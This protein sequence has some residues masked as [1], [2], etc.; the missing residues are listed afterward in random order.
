LAETEA[1]SVDWRESFL[2]T[3]LERD[4]AQLG[5]T[6]PAPTLRRFWTMVA[7]YHGQVWNATEFAR[8]LGSSEGTARRYL[9]ILT[10]AAMVRQL[11]GWRENI[12]KRQLKAPK[13]YVRDTGLLHT[14][15]TLETQE[16]LGG[17]PKVG[18]SWE[19]FA[20]EQLLGA[21]HSRSVYFWATYGGAE[22]DLLAIMGG[23]RF[24]FDVKYTDS[25]RMTRSLRTAAADLRLDRSFVVYPGTESYPLDRDAQALAIRDVVGIRERLP[26]R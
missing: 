16:Q 5:I 14:L 22:L 26:R 4:V 11:Q 23:Q 3:F 21:L 8:S 12:G 15:L 7:H 9:D 10:G 1:E 19:G 2:R 13:I 25:P 17:H 20:I 18:A 24:G 6:I